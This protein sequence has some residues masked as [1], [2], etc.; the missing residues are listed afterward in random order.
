[1]GI[2][3]VRIGQLIWLHL[4]LG[5][6]LLGPVGAKLASTG[7]RLPAPA[8]GMPATPGAA[9]AAVGTGISGGGGSGGGDRADTRLQLV[10]RAPVAVAAPRAIG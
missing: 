1:L 3:I 6:L 2:T 5:L 9:G 10:D 4:F 7:Y 8:A